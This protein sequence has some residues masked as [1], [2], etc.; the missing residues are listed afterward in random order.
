MHTHLILA[1]AI[2]LR[3]TVGAHEA[4]GMEL[5]VPKEHD[6]AAA[7]EAAARRAVVAVCLEVACFA[8]GKERME[9]GCCILGFPRFR[10]VRAL[11]MYRDFA[12]R[13][14]FASDRIWEKLVHTVQDLPRWE[15]QAPSVYSPHSIKRP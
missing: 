15:A 6:P 11:G 7:D 12:P 4:V 5:V 13:L 14:H 10:D 8:P 2:Q 3:A 9:K 1:I